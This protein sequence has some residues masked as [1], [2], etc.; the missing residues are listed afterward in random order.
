MGFTLGEPHRRSQSTVATEH[1]RGKS[2]GAPVRVLLD[3]FFDYSWRLL[4]HQEQAILP[5]LAVFRGSL[6]LAEAQ[7]VTGASQ[8]VLATLVDKSLFAVA[9]DG[10]YDLHERLRQYLL[11]KLC[12][13]LSVYHAANDLHG[14]AYLTL[15]QIDPAEFYKQTTLQRLTEDFD[16]IHAAWHWA[17][18]HAHWSAIRRARR[19]LHI[20][21]LCKIWFPEENEF[22][23]RTISHLKQR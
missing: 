1:C 3:G 7:A 23:E 8:F 16:N 22:Y 12:Q 2:R 11:D 18:D 19:E 4:S 21:C 5:Q 6:R 17:V 14:Q 9:A 10:R 15:L 13:D 20:F